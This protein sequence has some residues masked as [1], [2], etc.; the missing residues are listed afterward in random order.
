[1]SVEDALGRNRKRFLLANWNGQSRRCGN[2][3]N[4]LDHGCYA[5]ACRRRELRRSSL[6]MLTWDPNLASPT[7]SEQSLRLASF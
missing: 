5:V 7:Q 2:S 1:M 3:E 4:L 6:C